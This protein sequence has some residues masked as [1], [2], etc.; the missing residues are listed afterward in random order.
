MLLASDAAESFAL[1]RSMLD[2]L[3]GPIPGTVVNSSS[4]NLTRLA[5]LANAGIAHKDIRRLLRKLED[6]RRRS[7]WLL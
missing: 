7:V 6:D 1:L 2:I 3:A 5:E 4:D